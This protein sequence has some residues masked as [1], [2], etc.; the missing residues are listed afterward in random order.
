MAFG[1]AVLAISGIGELLGSRPRRNE[2]AARRFARAIPAR[3]RPPL[4]LAARIEAAGSPGGLGA[5][6]LM[7]IKALTALLATPVAT[8]SA[9]AAPGRLGILLTLAGPVAGFLAPD[10]WLARR[11]RARLREAR[12]DLPTLLDLLRVAIDAGLAPSRAL[13]A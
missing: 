2:G 11:T 7:A 1:A 6:E 13:A 12:R 5:S 3:L 9:Q 4:D 10:L 8:L